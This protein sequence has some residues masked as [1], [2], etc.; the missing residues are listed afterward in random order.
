M[1]LGPRHPRLGAAG[2]SLALPLLERFY[3]R[4]RIYSAASDFARERIAGIK[5]KLDRG[6]TVYLA[7][8]SAAGTHNS[9]VALVEVSARHGPRLIFNNEEERFSA[10]KHTNEYPQK[11]I[12]A[13]R[14]SMAGMGLDIGRIDGWFS[15]WDY[16]A[17]GATL[18]RTLLEEAPASFSMIRGEPTPLFNLRDLDRGTR[19]SRHIARQLGTG[20]PVALIGTPHHDNHAWY[21]FAVS[22]FAHS[23]RPVMVAVLDGLGDRGAITLY[24]CEGGRMRQLYSNDSVFDSLGIF[25]AVISSTQG[26]WTWLSS[27]G[28]YMGA[29][30]YGNGDRKTNPYYAALRAIFSLQGEGR[31]ALNRDLANW[32]RDIG[33]T[34]YTA[35][36]IRILGEPIALKDMWNPDAVLRVED[37]RHKP[38]TQERLD[39]AAAT[40]MVFED[41]LI[42]VVDHFIRS[43]GSDRLVLT[44]GIALN[45]LGNM[46]LLEHFDQDFYRRELGQQTRLHLWVPPVPNDAGVTAG[47]AFMGAYMAGYG[48]GLPIEHAFYCGPPPAENDIRAAL[49]ASADVEWIE[50]VP[51]NSEAARALFADFMAFM[52]SQDAI[53]ALYQGSAETG[54]RALGHRSILANPCNPKTRENLNA[55]VKYREAIRPLA[56]MLT[57]A[58]A[59]EF[60]ELSE[61]ASGADYNA[62]NYMVLTAHAKPQARARIPSVVHA[63]GTGRL[64]I[65]RETADPLTYVYLKALGRRIGVEVAVNT[66]FN[67]AGPIA[68]TPAQ[69]LDTLRRSKG[70]DAVLMFSDE[71]P[72]FA[73]LHGGTAQSGGNRFRQWLAAWQAERGKRLEI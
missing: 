31:I 6:E 47:A 22:P 32:P 11:S 18:I 23:R 50:L 60:F 39:K 17:F 38:S 61:G 16:P 27:E 52:T 73:A 56:P 25:Y 40:Q 30:A 20:E 4:R 68:Q 67:V 36:L 8:V 7:G 70:L 45:A 35:D 64:Q 49:T 26:G 29:T 14:A 55:Q 65:V 44:G 24:L 46:R 42:H 53:F 72:V 21:S 58:A 33:H 41:A 57:L 63:D 59:L 43:T 9:G 51:A 1:R 3:R 19:A 48:I 10:N 13:M 5:A 71:G 34:P 37:I 2:F 69:A 54:P 12:E 62:Y 28:R 15:A 66:S